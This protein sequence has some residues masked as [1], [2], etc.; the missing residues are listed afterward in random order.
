MKGSIHINHPLDGWSTAIAEQEDGSLVVTVAE[1]LGRSWTA[2]KD[3]IAEAIEVS[4]RILA[5]QRSGYCTP[6]LSPTG[7]TADVSH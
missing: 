5:E 7:E 1:P 6:P 2:R 4:H 3:T